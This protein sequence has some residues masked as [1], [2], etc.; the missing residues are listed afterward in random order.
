[1]MCWDY[2]PLHYVGISAAYGG[3]CVDLSSTA[4]DRMVGSNS[5]QCAWDTQPAQ[6][7]LTK[8]DLELLAASIVSIGSTTL[9]SYQ[10]QKIPS[11]CACA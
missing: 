10:E 5:A 11:D 7:L 4:A 1:M 8:G 9:A 2:S 6:Q 3:I